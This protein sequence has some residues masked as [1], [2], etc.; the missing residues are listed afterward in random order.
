VGRKGRRTELLVDASVARGLIVA[1]I[2]AA[3]CLLVVA[4]VEGHICINKITEEQHEFGRHCLLQL[5]HAVCLIIRGCCVERVY[6][7][8]II[9]KHV[10]GVRG[11]VMTML[12]LRLGM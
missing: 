10:L 12:R 6:W 8:A 1:S 9:K 3:V 11:R 2:E 5:H 4:A 7:S